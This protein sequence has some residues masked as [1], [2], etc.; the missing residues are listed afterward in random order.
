MNKQLAKQAADKIISVTVGKKVFC[1]TLQSMSDP[2]FSDIRHS[3][4]SIYAPVFKTMREM[5][6]AMEA[7]TDALD[8][9]IDIHTDKD[10]IACVKPLYAAIDD[11]NKHLEN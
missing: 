1:E 7:A 5:R 11:A 6:D 4:S 8:N 3:I 2:C 10:I 9:G